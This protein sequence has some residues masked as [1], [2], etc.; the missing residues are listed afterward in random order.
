MAILRRH[1]AIIT[2]TIALLAPWAGLTPAH[3]EPQPPTSAIVDEHTATT[4]DTTGM[5]TMT[6]SRL[7]RF[8]RS[9]GTWKPV[10]T[11]LRL[12]AA[13][14]YQPINTAVSMTFSNGGTTPLAISTIDSHTLAVTLPFTLPTPSVKLDTLTY[15]NVLPDVDLVVHVNA[16]SFSE[17]LVVKNATAA[18]NP[19][20]KQLRLNVTTTNLTLTVHPD[21]SS[22]ATTPQGDLIFT[23]PAP[24][25][26]DSS[27]TTA[28]T[29]PSATTTG[30]NQQPITV[31]AATTP[32]TPTTT[33][34]T[35]KLTPQTLSTD[36]G[37]TT[38][39]SDI[40]YPL[41][42]DPS[43]SAARAN[44]RTVITGQTGYGNTS[45]YM[46]V[47]Y[48]GWIPDCSTAYTTT[49]TARSYIEFLTPTLAPTNGAVATIHSASLTGS[50]VGSS[51]STPTQMSLHRSWGFN[52]TTTWP[53]PISDHIQTINVGGSGATWRYDNTSLITYIQEAANKRGLGI[54]FALRAGNESDKYQY[55]KVANNPILTITYT[56]PTTT[57]TL[58]SISNPCPNTPQ[59]SSPTPTL[60]AK[61]IDLN[62][63]PGD[64]RI[65]HQIRRP[66]GTIAA[67]GDKTTPSGT[68][69][70]Y[71]PTSPL[72]TGTY[73][74]WARSVQSRDVSTYYSP[75][76]QLATFTINTTTPN[77][78]AIYTNT[79][80]GRFSPTP[81][82]P[83]L[84][85]E[86]LTGTTP[87]TNSGQGTLTFIVPDDTPIS[88]Y[89]Y[90]WDG[91]PPTYTNQ[92]CTTPTTDGYITTT[93]NRAT[94][95]ITP[96]PGTHT[97]TVSAVTPSGQHSETTTYTFNNTN[98]NVTDNIVLQAENLERTTTNPE[99]TFIEPGILFANQKQLHFSAT[100]IGQSITLTLPIPTEGNWTIQPESSTSRNY[101]Q[102]AYSLNGQP[103]S[104]PGGEDDLGQTTPQ[105][106]PTIDH[107]SKTTR[108][109][110]YPLPE[111][112]LTQGN[113]TLTITITGHNP[114]T[115]PWNNPYLNRPDNAMSYT[116]DQIRLTKTG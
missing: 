66:D 36:P 105:P 70:S 87:Y 8:A 26:W 46:R 89:L 65:D 108:Q 16:E 116:I 48:C 74:Y 113:H 30:D 7:P 63:T 6:T 58:I 52:Q 78:P 42:I 15:P 14:R 88:G 24:T 1:A 73:T 57:P 41:Y 22:T 64:I 96:T 69:N 106:F 111:Q 107:Y 80:P 3:A 110:T 93:N 114:N 37:T 10:D 83:D 90:S 53:G 11:T 9:E 25:S 97:L 60:I 33:R 28:G 27:S 71:T 82:S 47:G 67:A 49:F 44:Y 76:A 29:Q 51:S 35:A 109:L 75:W 23:S 79:H 56:F 31:T 32:L 61:S 62:P 17:V 40:I 77:Q 84:N 86:A 115:T 20:L 45:D 50:L 101:G 5:V 92:T 19:Q 95:T 94:L 103:L 81:S 38:T 55:K 34:T 4:S 91:T 112:H 85:A 104:T 21:G 2:T 68:P 12:A 102:V 43:F 99:N 72:T 100:N 39:P 59:L 54:S 18:A 98:N 13:G